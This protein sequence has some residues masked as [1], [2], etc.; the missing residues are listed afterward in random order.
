MGLKDIFKRL[1]K[2]DGAADNRG[3]NDDYEAQKDD[4]F[5]ASTFAGGEAIEAA[6]DELSDD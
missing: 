3:A 6:D 4:A 5:I 2:P 1:T